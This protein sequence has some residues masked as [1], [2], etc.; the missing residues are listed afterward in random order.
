MIAH[1]IQSNVIRLIRAGR[2]R[3]CMFLSLLMAC[4]VVHFHVFLWQLSLWKVSL[5]TSIPSL[6]IQINLCKS[7]EQA[8]WITMLIHGDSCIIIGKQLP[9]AY[10]ADSW[11]VNV[12]CMG[13]IWM[14]WLTPSVNFL[15][16]L[17]AA[18]VNHTRGGQP[19]RRWAKRPQF[20]PSLFNNNGPRDGWPFY[21]D[22]SLSQ[23]G[24]ATRQPYKTALQ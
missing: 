12:I 14:P 21:C 7:R 19:S 15:V 22:H 8:N 13:C 2:I 5:N 9:T 16:P 10:S 24:R 6:P 20:S 1:H 11:H 17:W 4:W 23:G 18:Q 3:H